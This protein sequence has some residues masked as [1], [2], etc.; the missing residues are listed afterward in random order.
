MMRVGV[1]L[2][3]VEV[4]AEKM[5]P[6]RGLKV[7]DGPSLRAEAVKALPKADKAKK[8]RTEKALPAPLTI[9]A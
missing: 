2:G 4:E 1:I 7:F 5:N 8:I 3:G 9:A 6:P